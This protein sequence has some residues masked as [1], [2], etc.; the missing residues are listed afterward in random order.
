MEEQIA[1][2]MAG[3][4]VDRAQAEEIYQADK[5]IDRGE[6]MPFDL[7]P[8]QAKTVRQYTQVARPVMV[9]SKPRPRKAD[10]DKR[11]L[12]RLLESA[13]VNS[14]AEGFTELPFIEITNPERELVFHYNGKKYKIT[15]SAP[16]S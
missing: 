2:I 9:E 4:G 12:V 6:P 14:D 1:R 8:E 13:L 5:A 7:D 11:F 3:L 15:L 10:E 16:R